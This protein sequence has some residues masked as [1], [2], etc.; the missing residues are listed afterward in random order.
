MTDAGQVLGALP[1]DF[2]QFETSEGFDL[3]SGAEPQGQISDSSVSLTNGAAGTGARW[4][5]GGR[6]GQKRKGERDRQVFEKS[7]FTLPLCLTP[8]VKS[9][10][11]THY[12][13]K[14]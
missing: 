8:R 9:P 5:R 7:I 11:F 12:F 1:R 10:Y 3:G 4:E 14:K 13:K 2:S 6:T